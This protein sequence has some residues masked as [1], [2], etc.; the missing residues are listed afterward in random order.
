MNSSSLSAAR[1]RQ[2]DVV[3]I[4]N[5]AIG[6]QQQ[7]RLHKL[8]HDGLGQMLTSATF[9][10][11]SLRSRLAEL[12][13]RETEMVDEM[14]LLLN[15]AIAES[16]TLAARCEGPPKDAIGDASRELL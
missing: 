16:R 9:V 10:A 7:E 5:I 3:S 11:C 2:R 4:E 8:L 14:I 6:A 12:G 13:L 1:L 15:D